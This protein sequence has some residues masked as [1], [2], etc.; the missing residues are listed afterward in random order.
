MTF[1]TCSV[2]DACQVEADNIHPR[3]QS[4]GEVWKSRP[5]DFGMTPSMT[6]WGEDRW[7]SMNII[8]S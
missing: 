8:I 2:Q 5:P 3:R 1:S 7:V 6:P 4:W